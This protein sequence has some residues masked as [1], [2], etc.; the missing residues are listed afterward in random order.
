M[1]VNENN[2]V[3]DAVIT[4]VDGNDENHLKKMQPYLA[5][6]D[7]DLNDKNFATRFLHVNEIEYCVKSIIK[8]APYIRTIFIVTDN[9]IPAFYKGNEKDYPKVKIIDHKEI[10]KGFEAY[11]P[12]FNSVSIETMLYKI[13]DLSEHFVYFNDDLFLIK[14]TN[15]TDFFID[16]KPIIRGRWYPLDEYIWHKN[17]RKIVLKLLKKKSKDEIYGFRRAQQ[18]AAKMIGFD[19]KLFTLMHLPQP[20]RKSTIAA[21]YKKHPDHQ[22]TNINNKFRHPEKHIVQTI[23]NH[24]EIKAKTCILER[25]YKFLY[26]GGKHNKPLFWYKR[27]IKKT[28]NDANIKFLCLQSL[29]LCPEPKLKLITNWLQ[30]IVS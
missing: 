7:K 11:L 6:N 12:T 18:K 27:M 15:S 8:N 20:L 30:R 16:D 28:D 24:I 1:K 25:N 13:P 23:A 3:I 26:M 10:F 29:D 17:L 5:K 21:Y 9:Q 4:W 14:K 2:M 19:K 22:I